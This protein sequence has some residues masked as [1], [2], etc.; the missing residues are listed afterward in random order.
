MS[1]QKFA[2]IYDELMKDVPY[3]KWLERFSETIK[4]YRIEGEKVLDLAC[5][6][7][8]FSILLKENGFNPTGVDLSEEM[9]MVASEKAQQKGYHIPFYQQD[10]TQLEGLGTFDA[11]V[12]FCDSIN[13]LK[14]EEDVVNAFQSVLKHLKPGGLFMFDVHSVYKMEHLFHNQT[15]AINE[16]HVSYIW[17]CFQGDEPLSVEHELTFFVKKA[18]QD[19][20][21]RFDELHYQRTFPIEQYE[22]WLKNTGFELLEVFSDLENEEVHEKTERILFAARKK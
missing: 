14:K 3:E 4:K 22:A 7:G 9:L 8:V 15:Y 2:F 18:D 13:Y 20:Y 17:N 21:E 19:L 11:V 10:M 1:Y 5:G 16:E 12:I 6:T